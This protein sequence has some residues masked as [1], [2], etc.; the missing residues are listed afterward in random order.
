[1]SSTTTLQELPSE[2]LHHILSFLE[3]EHLDFLFTCSKYHQLLV[4][5]H[6]LLRCREIGFHDVPFDPDLKKVLFPSDSD[7]FGDSEL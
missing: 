4:N 5:Q 1:M 7:W 6:I 3:P 2:I